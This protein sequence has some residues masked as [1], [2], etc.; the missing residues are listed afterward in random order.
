MGAKLES[1][2]NGFTTAVIT[3]SPFFFAIIT[4]IETHGCENP[5]AQSL[6]KFCEMPGG[7]FEAHP[8][9]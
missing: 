5:A 1:T 9:N 6:W 3:A 7:R 4:R 8:A 2:G